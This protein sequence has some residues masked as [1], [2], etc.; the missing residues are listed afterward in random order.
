MTP[1]VRPGWWASQATRL[2]VV[3]QSIE[4]LRGPGKL[5][6]MAWNAVARSRRPVLI[7]VHGR[8]LLSRPGN[9]YPVNVRRYPLYN[10]PLVDLVAAV[11]K[12]S[13]PVTVIDVGAAV[14][15]TALLLLERVP[16]LLERLVCIDGDE[17][18]LPL[19][20]ANVAHDA[21]V[22]V[23]PA[24]LGGGRDAGVPTLVVTHPGTAS[25]QGPATVASRTL[26]AV[27]VDVGPIGVLKVDLDGWDGRI[28]T[29][30][31]ALLARLQP[32]V[33]FEW[34]P[35]LCDVTDNDSR[36]AFRVLRAE[37]YD[38][39]V[40]FDKTGPFVR[41]IDLADDDAIAALES[42]CRSRP[43]EVNAHFD[44]AALPPTLA[45]AAVELLRLSTSAGG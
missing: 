40:F 29:G 7:R 32:A 37:G 22:E 23:R 15:D 30:A 39:A 19:L 34:D 3:G 42:W 10:Q 28:L 41:A 25:A 26:D 44:V 14:G 5:W 33:L 2:L 12:V 6:R 1:D 18:T 31:T 35:H 45:G 16:Q 4:R 27:L 13:G 9:V 21:R 36:E 43:V 20:R 8:A 38:R 24:M 17:E 11:A